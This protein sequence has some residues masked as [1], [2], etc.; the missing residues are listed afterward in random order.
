MEQKLK[1]QKTVVKKVGSK[2]DP[3]RTVKKAKPTFEQIKERAYQIYVESGYRGNEIEN[4]IK[5]EKELK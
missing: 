5:A 1:T 4:W 2:L 3:K